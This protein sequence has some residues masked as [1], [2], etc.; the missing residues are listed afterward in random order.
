MEQPVSSGHTS[1]CET[2][3]HA[4]CRSHED[5]LGKVNADC[6]NVMMT[7]PDGRASTHFHFG[8][9]MP[10]R[11]GASIPL[12]PVSLSEKPHQQRKVIS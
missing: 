10:F 6:S 4:T 8:T 11:T 5:M 12:L 9:S 7:P 2:E 3:T 1:S